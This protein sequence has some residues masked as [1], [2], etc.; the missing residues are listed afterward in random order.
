MEPCASWHVTCRAG[1][2]QTA[3]NVGCSSDAHV[4][5]RVAACMGEHLVHGPKMKACKASRAA[6]RHCNSVSISFSAAACRQDLTARESLLAANDRHHDRCILILV[7]DIASCNFSGYNPHADQHKQSMRIV[8][9]AT[10]IKGLL[11]RRY[12]RARRLPHH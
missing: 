8:M 9:A 11:P 2:A 4:A 6:T 5:V 1:A 12:L 10:S 7:V 3:S